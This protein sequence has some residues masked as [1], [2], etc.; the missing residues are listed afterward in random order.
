MTR[1]FLEEEAQARFT[2]ARFD[3]VRAIGKLAQ[4]EHASFV[5]VCGD[6]FES[7]LVERKTVLRALE[8]MASISVPVFL[9]PGNHD[10]LD[11]ASVFRSSTFESKKPPNVHL[12]ADTKPVAIEPGVELVGAPWHTKRP[13]TDLVSQ[14]VNQIP[15][16]AGVIRIVAGHG[17]LDSLSPNQ[18]NPA[19]ISSR[20]VEL[21]IR[22]GLIHYVA[23][24]ERHSVTRGSDTDRVWFSG[25]PEATDY[26]EEKSGCA[27]IVDLSPSQC[28]VH[29][30]KTGSWQFVHR[31]LEFSTDADIN[32]LE[33]F[34]KDTVNKDKTIVRLGL[35]GVLSLEGRARLD[36]LI[37]EHQNL[38][39]AIVVWERESNIV[40][41][42]TDLDLEK[43][44]L[45]G[46][47]KEAPSVS[48][49]GFRGASHNDT[50]SLAHHE[51]PGCELG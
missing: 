2:Q 13:L 23:L 16:S 41:K 50:P 26:L 9:L 28:Q 35:K 43:L 21:A 32:Q 12:L 3:A 8:A 18:D 36:E 48:C 1:H 29:E 49:I 6:V 45:S 38:F 40:L 15:R 19:L 46:F 47:A 42:P 27:L 10:P 22:E 5:L 17:D 39:A 20:E 51:L 11:A 33:S 14:A 44:S 7:N 25:T 4:E 34:L 24:G 31:S 37:Q 30:R